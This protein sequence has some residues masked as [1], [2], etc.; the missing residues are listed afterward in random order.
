MFGALFG[1]QSRDLHVMRYFLGSP[2]RYLFA[3]F[4]VG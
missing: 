1:E 2:K 4:P 3:P